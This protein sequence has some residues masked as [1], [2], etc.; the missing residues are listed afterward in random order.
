[1][2]RTL[3]LRTSELQIFVFDLRQLQASMFFVKYY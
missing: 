1:M 3:T 2:L